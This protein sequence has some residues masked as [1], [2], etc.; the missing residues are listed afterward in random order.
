MP[1]PGAMHGVWGGMFRAADTLDR[2]AAGLRID[3]AQQGTLRAAGV[4]L[5][6][7]TR[8][9]GGRLGQPLRCSSPYRRC[10]ACSM[11]SLPQRAP[12]D[13]TAAPGTNAA[14]AART[15][16]PPAVACQPTD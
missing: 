9:W 8:A 14:A 6:G 10:K 12:G 4:L 15:P 7:A 3:A 16:L 5:S 13:A 2:A 11:R 1:P